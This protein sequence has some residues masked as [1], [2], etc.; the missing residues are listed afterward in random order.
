M[1]S[2]KCKVQSAKCKVQ[3][4]KCK[5]QSAKCKVQS[6]GIGVLNGEG[7]GMQGGRFPAPS[8]KKCKI[9]EKFERSMYRFFLYKSKQPAKRGVI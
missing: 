9:K 3:S 8:V 1:Q 5:V 2:A 6:A 4:A 7:G